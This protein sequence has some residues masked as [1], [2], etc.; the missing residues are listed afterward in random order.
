MGLNSMPQATILTIIAPLSGLV[1]ARPGN[2]APKRRLGL[3]LL[4]LLLLQSGCA[5]FQPGAD[6]GTSLFGK[7][8]SAAQS[9]QIGPD[10]AADALAAGDDA[11]SNGELDK[12]LFYYLLTVRL[13]PTNADAFTRIGAIHES[14]GDRQ[15]AVLAYQQAIK[16]DSRHADAL[17]GLGILLAKQRDYHESKRLLQAAVSENRD[18]A[19]A[20]NALGVLA[21]LNRDYA[22]ARGH[23]QAA[24]AIAPRSPM[25]HNNL[26]YSRYL[27]GDN[28]AAIAAFETALELN[29][30]YSQAWRNLGLVYSRQQR[31]RD[32]LEAFG[33]VQD[34]A[35]AYND[36]GYIAM[37]S[38]RLDD[39]ESFFDQA[40]RMAPE[41]YPLAS[42]NAERLRV[43]RGEE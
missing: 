22:S 20:H 23:Y 39:A 6:E 19:R 10:N 36:V 4:L 3:L 43:L 13:E 17:A 7:G 24:L 29:P 11:L 15:R 5:Q 31:Y 9:G 41:H 30:N 2:M 14:R 21:D 34:T 18:L 16:A 42:E 27:A 33:K 8:R 12:A 38:G 25:L 26:G 40:L 37:I 1:C 28:G 32:A 35:K